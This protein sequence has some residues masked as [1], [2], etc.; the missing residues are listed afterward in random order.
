MSE[1]TVSVPVAVETATTVAPAVVESTGPVSGFHAKETAKAAILA[2]ASAERLKGKLADL[3]KVEDVK[4]EAKVETKPEAKPAE[5]KDRSVTTIAKQS[6]EIRDLKAKLATFEGK[7]SIETKA[8]FVAKLKADPSLLYKEIDDPEL[9]TKLANA[10]Y[11]ELSPE[12]QLKADVDAK[13]A[14]FEKKAQDSEKATKEA[15]TQAT[16][17]QIYGIT[18]QFLNQGLKDEAGNVVIDNSKWP[19]CQK[20]TKAGD[21]DAP[22]AAMSLMTAMIRDLGRPV[23]E[24]E[25]V[26]MLEIAYD[27]LETSFRKKGEVYRLDV[28][29]EDTKTNTVRANDRTPKTLTNARSGGRTPVPTPAKSKAEEKAQILERHRQARLRELAAA[30]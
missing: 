25:S 2:K 9:L 8:D 20:A 14:A 4:P 13:L 3:P 29:N 6:Q 5:V 23:T 21:T 22:R 27:Q 24:A 16:D 26:K 19:L 1:S 30:A 17:A 18:T 28:P 10:R 15:Q 11:R 7:P 12:E